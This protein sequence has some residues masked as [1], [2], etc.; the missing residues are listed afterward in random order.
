MLKNASCM[1]DGKWKMAKRG[2]SSGFSIYHQPFSSQA[3]FSTA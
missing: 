1:D 2:N 3:H